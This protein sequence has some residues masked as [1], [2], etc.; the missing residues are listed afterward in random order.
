MYFVYILECVDK[1]LYTGIT[2]DLNR[3]FKQHKKGDGGRYTRAKHV[4]KIVH[5][6]EHPNRSAA[7]RREAQIKSLPRQ[8]KLELIQ[9]GS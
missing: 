5:T 3:R 8:K 1:S 7:Q 4:V 9:F 2:N 6:E